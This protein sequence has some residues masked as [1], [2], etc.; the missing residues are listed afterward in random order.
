MHLH[1]RI[2]S[3]SPPSGTRLRVFFDKYFRERNSGPARSLYKAYPWLRPT[4]VVP[5]APL[6]QTGRRTFHS[7]V[8]IRGEY[9][10]HGQRLRCRFEAERDVFRERSAQGGA[11][12]VS[13][14]QARTGQVG[15]RASE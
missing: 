8:E 15:P 12:V 14:L 11:D 9:P 2:R 10:L 13:A 3:N 7:K 6:P 4:S 1:G 5:R